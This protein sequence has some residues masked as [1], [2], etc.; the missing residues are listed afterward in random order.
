MSYKQYIHKAKCS[1]CDY[2][3]DYR[4][5]TGIDYHYRGVST[6]SEYH[7]TVYAWCNDCKQFAPVQLG[8][9]YSAIQEAISE[10]YNKLI[11]LE[12]SIVKTASKRNE[13]EWTKTKLF[14]TVIINSLINRSD[15]H[16]SCIL[17]GSY[18]VVFKD[19]EGQIW[20]CPKCKMGF[21]TLT[22]E[23]HDEDILY[24]RGEKFIIPNRNYCNTIPKIVNCGIDIINNESIFF[25]IRKNEKMLETLMEKTSYLDRMALTYAILV[26]LFHY[27]KS[28]DVFVLDIMD[29]LSDMD[30]ITDDD[31]VVVRDRFYDKIDYFKSEIEIE[32]NCSAFIPSAI[33]T[34]LMNP[35]SPSTRNITGTDPIEAIA[36]WKIIMD[37]VRGYFLHELIKEEKPRDE[38][39]NLIHGEI[40]MMDKDGIVVDV[41]KPINN[42]RAA[43]LT[44]EQLDVML[45]E[46]NGETTA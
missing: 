42:Q 8:I 17:C 33:I 10:H 22:I 27:N 30:F 19:L 45:V 25:L 20:R 46:H 3:S 15:T 35:S 34:T 18:N 11:G 41:D 28:K 6:F 36:H 1:R 16:T 24:R 38:N 29:M 7:K 43:F 9:D 32:L 4:P 2:I 13:I 23:E 31:R 12:K 5:D 44:R 21:L 40:A 37:T 39:G 14:D 26:T